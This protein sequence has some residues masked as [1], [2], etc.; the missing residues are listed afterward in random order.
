MTGQALATEREPS[1][2]EQKAIAKRFEDAAATFERGDVESALQQFTLLSQSS[3]SPNVLLYIG[4]CKQKL[5]RL[6]DA[7]R[8][9]A[10]SARSA[11]TSGEE[12][13]RPTLLAA[14]DQLSVLG[15]Q[16]AKLTVSLA[17]T[18]PGLSL[19]VDDELVAQAD[20][21]SPIVLEQG[22]H[23]IEAVAAGYEPI[24]RELALS[25]G[26]NKTI[27]LLLVQQGA[28]PTTQAA[29]TQETGASPVSS[30]GLPFTTFGI[31]ATGVGA[32]GL[33]TFAIAGLRARSIERQLQTECSEPCSDASHR[34]LADDGGT[35]QLVANVGLV[36][37]LIGVASAAT[38]F[39]LGH[40]S[41][42]QTMAYVDV[43]PERASLALRGRF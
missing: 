10:L 39:Y 35:Y 22:T 24:R 15:L 8:A 37:G 7:Y 28:K 23:H 13:Y 29:P 32:V 41:K 2:Q 31:V 33:G 4:Y 40:A 12:R 19:T 26:D 16:L 34:S 21:G 9:F 17:E 25:K 43:T 5:G 36:T 20:L 38:F 42:S 3:D 6:R 11:A 18:P 30:N 27:T 1:P 14:Q